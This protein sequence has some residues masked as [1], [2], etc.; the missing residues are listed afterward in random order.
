MPLTDLPPLEEPPRQHTLVAGEELV[1][2]GAVSD[3]VY[4]LKKGLLRAVFTNNNG[5]EFTK[6]F[7]WGEDPILLFRSLL[8]DEPLP[9]SI[10]ALESSTYCAMRKQQ[11]LSLIAEHDQWRRYHLQQ[12]EAHLLVKER[13]EEFLLLQRPEQRVESFY[14]LYPDLIKRLPDYLVASYLGMTPISYSRIK[15]RLRLNKG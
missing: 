14:R 2:Q 13:K 8:T 6:E 7:Y 9:Y 4:W 15:K 1:S 11:Y 3:H 12:V 5:K 10:V